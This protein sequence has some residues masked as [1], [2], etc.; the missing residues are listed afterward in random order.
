LALVRSPPATLHCRLD[1]LTG[2]KARNERGGE[3]KLRQ[4]RLDRLVP[5]WK[6]MLMPRASSFKQVQVEPSKAVRAACTGGGNLAYSRNGSERSAGLVS[7]PVRQMAE[8]VAAIEAVCR[9]HGVRLADAAV[10]FPLS[11][12]AVSSVV[13]GAVTA[14]EVRRNIA[15]LGAPIP[16]ALWTDLREEGLLDPR[17]PLPA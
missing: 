8:E 11:H 13:L 17:A 10:R 16:S 4:Q 6:V 5:T 7:P 3:R 1:R 2:L 12:P 15:A 9:A 14:E